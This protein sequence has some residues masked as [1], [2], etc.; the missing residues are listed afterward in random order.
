MLQRLHG[1]GLKV[2]VWINSYI[3]QRSRFFAEGAAKGF[4]IKRND[5]SVWQTDLWQP[6][7]AI[8]DFTNPAAREWFAG[9]ITRLLDMGVDA[10]KTDF[11]ERF[12]TEGV[13]YHDGSDPVKMH[14][15]YPIIYNE[16]VFRAIEARRGPGEAVLFARSSYASGSGFRCTGEATAGPPLSR[17][18][19]RSAAACRSACAVSVFGVTTSAA[20]RAPR[21]PPSTSA[22][23]PS[24]CSPAQPSARQRELSHSVG[25]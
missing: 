10:I 20:S 23:P 15:F 4:F 3:A 7:M 24:A 6:G 12:P 22:G 2:C 19:S 14:N 1:R 25:V 18:P 5:G 11:G 17:W 9:H 8:V 21:R 16:I 13:V